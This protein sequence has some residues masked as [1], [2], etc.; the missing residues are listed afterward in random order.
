MSRY[1]LYLN[2]DFYHKVSPENRVLVLQQPK[3]CLTTK[4]TTASE[5]SFGAH[6]HMNRWKYPHCRSRTENSTRHPAKPPFAAPTTRH[7]NNV[8]PPK[9]PRQFLP[10]RLA[11]SSPHHP[12]KREPTLTTSISQ[13]AVVV[14]TVYSRNQATRAD[15][16]T[17]QGDLPLASVYRRARKR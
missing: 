7:Q 8:T 16:H 3:G 17:A 4:E 5:L 13:V 14:A 1:G 6:H 12:K 11:L 2:Q 10:F 9:D 15:D